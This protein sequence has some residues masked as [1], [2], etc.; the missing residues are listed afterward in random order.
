MVARVIQGIQSLPVGMT[1]LQQV[2]VICDYTPLPVERVRFLIEFI[3]S[4]CPSLLETFKTIEVNPLKVLA[5]P[6]STC[7]NCDQNL[8]A[9]HECDVSLYDVQGVHNVRKITLRC[10][11]EPPLTDILYSRHLI[12][13]DKMLRSGLNLHYA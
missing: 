4:Q 12:I 8:L 11:V 3:E 1:R 9:Y 6:V 10:T 7:Y 2:R 13:Q 5:P